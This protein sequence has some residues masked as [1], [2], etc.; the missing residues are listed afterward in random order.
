V[1]VH[2]DVFGS[3]VEHR[4]FVYAY[5]IGAATHER[6]VGAPLTKVTQSVGD[7]KQ[8]GTTTSSSYILGFCG[9]L[10]YTW[11]F[12][13]S[14]RNKWGTQNLASTQSQFPIDMA[15][16]KVGIR[17]TKKRKWDHVWFKDWWMVA[18]WCD[19]WLTTLCGLIRG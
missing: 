7:P 18:S 3:W 14:Q 8:F 17:K 4:I 16:H 13:R 10:S 11:L 6:M 19:E 9:R 1:V 2:L 12:A 5:G 15:T